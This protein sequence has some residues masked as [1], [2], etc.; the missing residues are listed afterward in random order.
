MAFIA[1]AGWLRALIGSHRHLQPRPSNRD[2]LMTER[3][4]R[5]RGPGSFGVPNPE[6]RGMVGRPLGQRVVTR[7]ASR[8]NLRVTNRAVADAEVIARPPGLVTHRAVP[9]RRYVQLGD[10]RLLVDV[11]MTGFTPDPNIAIVGEMLCV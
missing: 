6:R 5:R 9:H 1:I 4:L 8:G 7:L 11:C 2:E 10:R 3:T